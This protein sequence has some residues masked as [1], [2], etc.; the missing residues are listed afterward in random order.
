MKL[1]SSYQS[2]SVSN[3]KGKYECSH[4]EFT[5]YTEKFKG[6]IDYIFYKDF[7]ENN[8]KVRRVL[9]IPKSSVLG[10]GCPNNIFPSDHLPIIAD[11]DYK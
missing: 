1:K 2:Y 8:I 4:P 10:D 3:R 6:T 11:F 7:Q 5:N 9:N